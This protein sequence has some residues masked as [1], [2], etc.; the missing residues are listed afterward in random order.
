MT[1]NS[2]EKVMTKVQTVFTF[3]EDIGMEFGL[4]K[5]GV[6]ILK[7]GKLVKFDGIHLPHQDIMKEVDENGY[8]YLGILELDEIKEHE[9]KNKITVE[10]KRRLRLILKSKLNGKN[11]IQAINTWAVAMLRYG[12]GII[13]WKVDELK[14][15]GQNNEKD[16]DDLWGPSSKE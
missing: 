1:S 9:M 7:K 12:A 8:T 3:S 10:Y 2:L 13:N 15:N 16:F 14:K 5:C 11:K 4:K 6:V